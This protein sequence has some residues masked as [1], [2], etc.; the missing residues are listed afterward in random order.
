MSRL[1]LLRAALLRERVILPVW[2]AGIAL[3]LLA[4]G[5]AIER[6]FGGSEERAAI[7]ALAA[8]NPAFLFLRGAPDG[9]GVG[10][11][12]FFQTFSFLAVL[13]GLMTTFLVTRH[14]RAD[15]ERGRS[16]LVAAAPLRRTDPL[17]VALAVALLANLT[18]A[19]LTTGA[20]L[21]IGLDPAGAVVTGLAL[22]AVGVCFAGVAALAAEAMPSPRGANGIAAAAVG[23]AYLVRGAGDAL[24]RAVDLTRVEPAWPALLSPIG[25]AQ[26]SRP[27]SAADPL[28]LL[29][30][31]ALGVVLAA[32]AIAARRRRD[33][34]ASLVP[35]RLGRP[36]WAGAGATRL[37]IRGQLGTTLGWAIGTALLGVLAG[38][39]TPLIVEA[40]AANDELAA[41]IRRLA[42]GLE[43]D[44]GELFAIAL[45]GIAGTLATAA[46][47]HA[48]LRLRIDE[49]EDRAELLLASGLGRTGWYARQV[50][51][52]VGSMLLVAAVGGLAAGVGFVLSGADT[53]RV[54]TSLAAIGVHVPAGSVFLALTA[55]AFAV[56]PR[57]TVG[58]AWGLLVVGL[59]VGQLGD[60][61]GLPDWAQDLS[62]FHHVPAVPIQEPDPLALLAWGGAGL[63]GLVLAGALLRRRDLPA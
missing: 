39:L 50:A 34:G 40:M 23:I 51:V 14:T 33:L 58:I 10:A 29:V 54:A 37:A 11:V 48:L 7:V 63:A 6:E 17:L 1:V 5:V 42:P 9:T 56:R 49:A 32:G 28:P 30:P 15:E 45:L 53:G 36:A 62:P 13:V 44:S 52:A 8:G 35:E 57:W 2:L 22:G 18:V 41:L 47:V 46:G 21:A 55:L 19:A 25:W 26:A 24:G 27:F 59:V 61:L 3:L 20:G 43:A 16:E 60:L 4:S 12:V 31:V 38:A